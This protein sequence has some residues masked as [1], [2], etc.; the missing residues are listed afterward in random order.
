MKG[1]L[2]LVPI[3]LFAVANCGTDTAKRP[4]SSRGGGSSATTTTT[5]HHM[6]TCQATCSTASDCGKANDP[7]YDSAHF[8]CNSGVCQWQGCRS[9]S[10]CSSEAHGGKFLCKANGGGVPS[11]VP[12]CEKP[13][14]CVPPGQSGA[15]ND[16]SH[17]ACNEGACQ[18]L[19]C[20]SSAE[21]ASALHTSKVS[22]EEPAGAPARTCVPT[23]SSPA[24]CVTQ[25]AGLLGD[26]N[27]YACVS[28]RCEWLGCKSTAECTQALSSS[29]Y[30]CQ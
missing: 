28:Q 3:A 10:E 17:F 23:C 27:H 16:A 5:N 21:C 18:W 6:A 22:C 2:A 19:G 7:L 8:A 4:P 26:K 24:D 20:K 11:C 13:A 1:V 30:I 29:H 12:A 15:L 14:D 25:G 9:A